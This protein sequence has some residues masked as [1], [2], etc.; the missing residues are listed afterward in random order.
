MN[1]IKRKDLFLYIK[2]RFPI[3]A[4][5]FFSL[6]VL[7]SI[8]LYIFNKINV[9]TSF[10]ICIALLLLFLF[11]IRLMDDVKDFKYDVV[12]HKDRAVQRGVMS[13]AQLKKL[14]F[15]VLLLEIILQL[16]LPQFAIYFYLF[17]IFYSFLMHKDFFSGG[18]FKNHFFVYIL[19]H[20]IIF[21]FYIYYY[22]CI[23]QNKIVFL[24]IKDVLFV[25]FLFLTM[26]IYE[27]SRKMNHRYDDN[28]K[29]TDDTYIYKWGRRNVLSLLF[30]FILIQIFCLLFIFRS[31]NLFLLMYVAL[32]IIGIF[33]SKIN[34]KESYFILMIIFSLS[35]FISYYFI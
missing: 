5:L 27:I 34:K 2:E 4:A 12:F 30:L 32:L 24:G 20:Q 28:N 6:L 25:F 8:N 23:F 26:Y 7:T 9:N 35:T 31:I 21:A 10:F 19:L 17:L 11:R 29:K 14:L 1:K 16:F 18:F 33:Y 15:I 13:I 22:F 3:F